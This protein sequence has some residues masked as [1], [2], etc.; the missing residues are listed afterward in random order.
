MTW[1]S[2]PSPRALKL[3]DLKR[4][5]STGAIGAGP[6]KNI[7][8]A[9]TNG[10]PVP[11]VPIERKSRKVA[12]CGCVYRH[13]FQPRV[14]YDTVHPP[15]EGE[16]DDPLPPHCWQRQVFWLKSPAPFDGVDAVVQDGIR[17]ERP[18]D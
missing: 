10:D 15:K 13:A 3:M 18:A 12:G 11:I 17:D 16:A 7:G 8:P 4:E 1:Y 6:G 9:Q 2:R 14:Y 5:R